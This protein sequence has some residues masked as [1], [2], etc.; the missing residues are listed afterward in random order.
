MLGDVN[1][2]VT[3]A[4]VASVPKIRLILAEIWH[5]Y[6]Y[7]YCI[8]LVYITMQQSAKKTLNLLDVF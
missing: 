5:I 6:I 7:I 8:V 1:P 3:L 4:N 2:L